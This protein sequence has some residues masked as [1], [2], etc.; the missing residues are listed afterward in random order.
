MAL[1]DDIE[2]AR[3]N[4]KKLTDEAEQFRDR[5][6]GSV[7]DLNDLIKS[8]KDQGDV[9]GVIK[10]DLSSQANLAKGLSGLGKESLKTAQQRK[11]FETQILN[12][13]KQKLRNQSKIREIEGR[14]NTLLQDNTK[15]SEAQ[16]TALRKALGV[17]TDSN[18][19]LAT[20]QKGYQS[21]LSTSQQ[22]AKAN[23]FRGFS[24]LVKDVP[25]VNKLLGNMVKAA[26]EFNEVLV[27]T[28]S[29]NKALLAGFSEYGKLIGK[30][31]LSFIILELKKAGT[32]LDG[33]AVKLAANLNTSK[34]SALELTNQF[35][36]Q[37]YELQGLAMSY[38]KV[39][40]AQL[41][42]T[43]L[44]GTATTYSNDSVAAFSILSK[45]IG[46]SAQ[47]ASKLDEFFRAIGSSAKDQADIISGTVALENNRLG[48]SISQRKIFEEVASISTNIALSIESQGNSLAK[49]AFEANRLGLSMQQVEKISSSILD[50]ESSIVNELEAELLIGRDINLERARLAALN[51]DMEKVVSEISRQGITQ[52]SFSRMNTIQ[53]GSIAKALGMTAKEMGDMFVKQESLT[54]LGAKDEAGVAEMIKQMRDQGMSEEDI[55]KRVGNKQ[56][57]AAAK[58]RI[59]QDQIQE[60]IDNLTRY[61]LPLL[62]KLLQKINSI[63]DYLTT[64]IG[65]TRTSL[66]GV[67]AGLGAGL[68]GL[69]GSRM[70]VK[71]A[72]KAIGVNVG[73][74][75]TRAMQGAITKG[76][77][78]SGPRVGQ[79]FTKVG[80]K[81]ASPGQVRM[82]RYGKFARAGGGLGLGIAGVGLGMAGDYAKGQGHEGLGAGLNIAGTTLTGASIGMMLGPYGAAIGAGLGAL[83][84]IFQE[85]NGSSDQS[86]EEQ[87]K[88]NELLQA[89]NDQL[90]KQTA[91]LYDAISR[92]RSVSIDGDLLTSNA[93]VSN[94]TGNRNIL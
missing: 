60:L 88:T 57:E 36:D 19:D 67:G 79:S 80:G 18:I 13:E 33:M 4:F 22:I 59:F 40:E 68:L 86:L 91:E 6:K 34:N 23:P 76:T 61:V 94:T 29:K 58:N 77:F 64:T 26:D 24:D 17:L 25:I 72:T 38:R 78:K 42:L 30:A 21:V 55:T 27:E 39:M 7:K 45:N 37:S 47:S 74:S 73:K 62:T 44:Q 49:A 31:T 84:G 81:F 90:M 66:A 51:N 11:K 52:G 41:E 14:I 35:V 56:L 70:L 65:G 54:R 87:K 1:G 3:K 92:A 82:A 2:K 85:V 89:N 20:L 93:G 15:E 8:T 50:F 28:E 10:D 69:A 83:Y 46:V 48:V 16:V 71:G 5:I 9:L 43:T 75:T 63:F 53:Q 12:I 32:Y